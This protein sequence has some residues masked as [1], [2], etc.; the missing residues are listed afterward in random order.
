MGKDGVGRRLVTVAAYGGGGLSVLGASLYGVLFTEARLARRAIGNADGEPP[1][2]TGW[3]G[4][5]RPGPSLK[6]AVL[7]DSSAAGYG[8]ARAEETPGA[9]LG[10]GLAEAVD[11]RVYV[12]AVAKVGAQTR[13]LDRQIDAALPGEPHV[14]AILVGVNDITHARR[15]SE[16][17]SRLDAAVRRFRSAGVEVV[18][19]TCPDLGTI[20]PISPPLKQVARGWSRWLAAQQTVAVVG[21][22]GRTV[23]LGSM[24]GPEFA[25]TPALLFGPDRF[26]PSVQGYAS[27]AGAMLPSVIDALG[28]GSPDDLVPEPRRGDAVLPITEAALEAA[29]IPGTEIDATPAGTTPRGERGRWVQLRRR[30]RHPEAATESPHHV[31]AVES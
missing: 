15:P 10:S 9:R 4:R 16:S 26:H 3:Y 21:A 23:S 13:D 19:G 30:R 1:N 17:V 20:E 24:L 18:V 22:G 5:G 14:V 28:I 6:L 29:R 12:H 2:A 31:E 11:R 27:L 7:G 25:A 8:V